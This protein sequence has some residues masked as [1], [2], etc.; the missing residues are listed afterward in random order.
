MEFKGVI[1][2]TGSADTRENEITAEDLGTLRHYIIGRD[3]VCLKSEYE[4]TTDSVTV[5]DCTIV[6]Y[7]YVGYIKEA[8]F[9]FHPTATTQYHF[10]YGEINR[11]IVPNE[12]K[13]KV[14]N[15]QGSGIIKPNT[16]RQDY[17]NFFKTGIFQLPLYR[18]EVDIDG[19]KSIEDYTQTKPIKKVFTVD[20]THKITKI[21]SPTCT[22]TTQS[23]R[24]RSNKIATVDFCHL[25]IRDYIDTNGGTIGY[26]VRVI[27][28]ENNGYIIFKPSFVDINTDNPIATFTAILHKGYSI[29]N[30]QWTGNFSVT[31]NRNTFTVDLGLYT[32]YAYEEQEIEFTTRVGEDTPPVGLFSF[33]IDNY[34]Y[35]AE[36]GMSWGDWVESEYN[37]NDF[38]TVEDWYIGKD[39]ID[40]TGYVFDEDVQRRMNMEDLI[41]NKDYILQTY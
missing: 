40:T 2:G 10:I 28:T 35:Y 15:N 1:G 36:N 22:A 34:I 31:R 13:L 7:G 25:V 14:K 24:D 21:V 12:F 37:T 23:I 38:F 17:L 3:G 26:D 5:K 20:Q 29:N 16:F 18:V 39:L 9:Y 32:P 6:A 19:I 30:Y 33:T 4:D 8:T 27:P 41:E 11:S